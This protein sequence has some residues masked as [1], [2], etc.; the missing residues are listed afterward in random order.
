MHNLFATTVGK[1]RVAGEEIQP[2]SATYGTGNYNRLVS[3]TSSGGSTFTSIEIEGEIG[4][5]RCTWLVDTGA[6]ISVLQESLAE[7]AQGSKMGCQFSPH[8]VDGSGMG[9]VYDL[10][11]DCQ[12]GDQ[13]IEQHRFTVVQQSTY[14]AIIGMD[15]LPRLNMHLSIGSQVFVSGTNNIAD[16]DSGTKPFPPRVCRIHASAAVTVPPR[17]M[18]V[19]EGKL[20][21]DILPGTVGLIES[22]GG[23]GSERFGLGCGRVFDTV[24]E[25]RR[26]LMHVT[27][28]TNTPCHV[29]AG[30]F[31]G[32]FSTNFAE[33]AVIS[34][35]SKY[36]GKCS[37]LDKA[38]RAQKVDK[39]AREKSNESDLS[40]SEKHRL[41]K[42]IQKNGDVISIDDETGLTDVVEHEIPTGGAH[43]ISQPPRRVPF[44]KLADVDSFVQD[45][46]AKG[47]IRPS[48]SPWSSPLVM[49][50]KKDG[51]TRFCVDFRRLNES[52]V[53]DSFPIPRI[54]DSL[55]AL[56]GAKLF[57]T[58][59]LAK[60]YWQVPVQESDRAKTAFACHK[61]LFEFNTMP[62]GLKGA[63]ATFQRLM[64]S[65]LGELNWQILLI[66]LDDIIIYSRSFEE[67]LLHLQLVLDKL[68]AA[69]LKL[70]PSKCVFACTEVH[71][72]GFVVSPEGI[73]P[74]QGKTKAIQH[75]PRPTNVLEVRRFVG[76]AS[77]YRRFIEH[78]ADIAAPLHALTR[79]N[80]KFSWS[81]DCEQA[82][83]V[84]KQRLT[85]SPV[86]AYP[87]FQQEFTVETDASD[88]G[89]GAI[90]TQG[91]RVIAYASRALTAVEKNYSATEKECLGVVWS[92]DQFNMYLEGRH[93]TVITDHKPLTYLRQL[94]EP[95]GKLARWRVC[96]DVYDFTIKHRPGKLMT[97]ADALSRAPVHAVTID[98]VWTDR[99]L[100]A[101]QKEDADIGVIYRWAV[102]RK[103]P[104]NIKRHINSFIKTHGKNIKV[105]NDVLV[106]QSKRRGRNIVQMMVPQS[107]VPRILQLLHDQWGHFGA[108][109]TQYNVGTRFFWFKWKRD[110]K[111]WCRSCDVCLQRKGTQKADRPPVGELPIP[112]KPFQCWHMDFV[113]PLPKTPRGNRYIF[114]L[115]D[116]LSKWVEAFPVPDQTAK[117]TAEVLLREIVCRYGVPEVLHSDQGRNF[118]SELL[119]ELHTRLDIR[120]SRSA[121]YNPQCNGQ[122]ER[123]NR[124]IAERL[125][126]EIEAEDQ[127]DWDEKL[128][129]AL[130]AIRT[131]SSTTTGETPFSVIFGFNC[132]NKADMIGA[133]KLGK[134][135]GKETKDFSEKMSS[136]KQL[137]AKVRNR[138]IKKR[139]DESVRREAN[140]RFRQ[141]QLGEKVWIFYPKRPKGSAKKL[142]GERFQGPYEVVK[143][144]GD[145]S[146]EIKSIFGGG[147]RKI[148]NHRRLKKDYERPEHLQFNYSE[149][150]SD[151]DDANVGVADTDSI[152][153][154]DSRFDIDGDE[155][156]GPQLVGEPAAIR[157]Q[158]ERQA[159]DRYGFGRVNLRTALEDEQAEIQLLTFENN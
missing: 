119:R 38:D 156:P 100:C 17:S 58:L 107:Q 135:Q 129:I 49:V 73:K 52:T 123:M 146:Y 62:F 140:I 91:R 110:V 33:T 115:T 97:V 6:Q 131:T 109:K 50:R 79:A 80:V 69:G 77:Y 7:Q 35:L 14:P 82:F 45:G 120:R 64:T 28:P 66:Y 22:A 143:L 46:L 25:D 20:D 1:L 16:Q 124:T 154:E 26:V 144:I 63:P 11:T 116:P 126:M 40:S 90:L 67:H 87:D 27:N 84:L 112:Q 150:S 72:L 31:F 3:A 55:D 137:H 76:L 23:E 48:K 9:T 139:Q 96:L 114:S 105:I 128:P 24:R 153:S 99:E 78:F 93:F 148:V 94:K 130:S 113:G 117:T 56:G 157:P 85:S 155:I 15:L 88:L 106:M 104:K 81:P 111:D 19:I 13:H 103:K 151:S 122:V 95:R 152:A 68:R 44:H 12:V 18:Q 41:Y 36:P 43:P 21:G 51:S 141:F 147:K 98:G 149:E 92:L 121:P 74:D 4:G 8:T 132:R 108:A 75:F 61:G 138:I 158:R 83:C 86:L 71:Y 125:A 37:K 29:N 159:P 102:D 32:Q 34:E 70:N 127:T 5:Q 136:L 47:V 60:G 30:T 134:P 118:E 10:V 59:D 142:V 133:G 89:L 145:T 2:S 39:L 65:V 101:L 54:D 42:V 53:G 57:T